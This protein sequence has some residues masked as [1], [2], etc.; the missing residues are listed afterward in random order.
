[1]GRIQLPK[2]PEK[3]IAFFIFLFFFNSTIGQMRQ[4]YVDTF[5]KDNDIRRI[6]F[7]SPST[8]YVSFKEWIGYTTDS[9]HTFTK[10]YI[11]RNNVDPNGYLLNPLASF[12]IGGV[13]AIN[14]N[15]IIAYGGYLL[16]PAILRSTDGGNTFKVVYYSQFNNMQLRT[17]VLDMIFPENNGVGYA[18]DADRILKT[19]DFGVTWNVARVDPASYFDRLEAADNKIVTAMSTGYET[20]KLLQTTDGGLVWKAVKVPELPNGKFSAAYFLSIRK[21]YVNMYDE[22]HNSYIFKTTDGGLNWSLQNNVVAASFGTTKMKFINDSIGYAMGYPGLYKTI[23]SGAVWEKLAGDN[24]DYVLNDMQIYSDNHIWA[25]GT[26]GYLEM[27][28]NGGGMPFP[29]ATFLVDTSGV[30]ATG[31]VALHNYSRADYTYRWYKNNV[32]FSTDYSPTYVHKKDEYADTI[33]LIV[34]NGATSDTLIKYQYYPKPIPPVPSIISFSPKYGQK[35]TI[36]TIAGTNFI[37]V[38]AVTFGGTPAIS[39]N[40]LSPSSITAV[41]DSGMSGEI[42]VVTAYGNAAIQGFSSLTP[43]ISSFSPKSGGPG[44]VVSIT[45]ENLNL[46][47]SPSVKF[48][49]IPATSLLILSEKEVNATVGKGASGDITYQTEY[50]V[51]TISGFTYIPPLPAPTISSFSPQK[52][53]EG[54]EV[55]II[56]ANF[57][58]ATSVTFGGIPA[59]SFIV[60]SSA[61]IKAVVGKGASGKILVTTPTGKDSLGGFEYLTP[62]IYS[63]TPAIGG[64]GTSVNIT[65][66]NFSGATSVK[67]GGV[68][69]AFYT[70]NSDTG[71]TA[72][73][74]SGASGNVSV[75]SPHGA[76]DFPGF[77]FSD[78]PTITSFSPLFGPPGTEVKIH[79]A[80][81]SAVP[82]DNIVWFGAVKAKVTSSTPNTITV[83]APPAA[84]YQPLTVSSNGLTSVSSLAFLVTFPEKEINSET[85]SQANFATGTKPFDVLVSDLDG[86]G[87]PDVVVRSIDT[88]SYFKNNSSKGALKLGSRVDLDVPGVTVNL[89]I[90]D[91]DGDGKPDIIFSK[92]NRVA[93]L[94]NTSTQGNISFAS[95]KDLGISYEVR[96]MAVGDVNG[97]GKPDIAMINYNYTAVSL[98]TSSGSTLSFTAPLQ[99]KSTYAHMP[100]SI[101]IVDFDGDGKPDIAVSNT[102]STGYNEQRN[103]ALSLYRNTFKHDTVSFEPELNYGIPGTYNNIKSADLD[104]DGKPEIVY[105]VSGFYYKQNN[106]FT[107]ANRVT[108]LTNTS[109]PGHISFVA[110][111]FNSDN[112]NGN[113]AMGVDI[114][115]INGDS[116]P[117][118]AVANF[119][120][121]VSV[122]KNNGSKGNVSFQQPVIYNSNKPN[123]GSLVSR[124]T[125]ADLD[126]DLKPELL[127]GNTL[128]NTLT[129]YRSIDTTIK[130]EVCANGNANLISDVQGS[131]YQWQVNTGAG[132]TNLN[133]NTNYSGSNTSSLQITN[134]PKTWDNYEY[135]CLVKEKFSSIFSLVV[136]SFSAPGV[137][138]HTNDTIICSGNSA[139]FHATAV[140]DGDTPS[141]QWLVDE[142]DA[143]VNSTT[144]TTSKLNNHSQIKLILTSSALCADPVKVASNIVTI[145]IKERESSSVSITSSATKICSGTGVTFSTVSIN[146]GDAPSYQWQV[147]G[148]NAGIANSSF[149]SIALKN[150]DEVKVVMSSNAS[151]LTNVTA[152]SNTIVMQV[153]DPI[154][155]QLVFDN[156]SI[157]VSNPE[158]NAN[159]TWQI[160]NDSLWLD[161]V[162]T[163]TGIIYNPPQRGDYRVK[164]ATDLCTSFSLSLSVRQILRQSNELVAILYPNPAQTMITI[165]S[166]KSE[167]DWKTLTITNAVGVSLIPVIGLQNKH[168]LTIDISVLSRGTYFVTLRKQNGKQ[169]TLTFVKN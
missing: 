96:D 70:I 95:I 86:D 164:S 91:M 140:N 31:N 165:D 7:I 124:I 66:I 63:I 2:S 84:T 90:S 18:V 161:V 78:V 163:A 93:M 75:S 25:G 44:T 68:N 122:L 1:M 168:N 47:R 98:N 45:G 41:L 128:Y 110:H 153:E 129:I 36:I 118:I 22:D 58:E 94:K 119:T 146:G 158:P 159:Y 43:I 135:R 133:D 59:A 21:G 120:D 23:N 160:L 69:A 100:N 20:N 40:V 112:L 139:T 19:V 123:K 167:D 77:Q 117:D 55:I 28:S 9:G 34:S 126:D 74:G 130:E 62:V 56:G 11:T 48:G 145:S 83:T 154:T 57:N 67:F 97:D 64:K 103:T 85:Y 61:S 39:F 142:K 72:I 134:I 141:Y 106:T 162:P 152:S 107:G 54:D 38:S 144:F 113:F 49:G 101:T 8:G 29:L 27:S 109:A 92:G 151:C 42:K 76:F 33:K 116:R 46:G 50:G 104:G 6:S 87:K 131:V 121:H 10:K 53:D 127:I 15:T 108:V 89:K 65:G 105:G 30:Y 150:K 155:P 26:H 138:I 111:D 16:V 32:P 102:F 4:V 73:I 79:G 143:G 52:A 17:A 60:T 115:N 24:N 136:N 132:F 169:T 99:L 5:N 137:T 166:L 82:S 81:F 51:A 13:K 37:G 71:I 157:A 114:G 125:I 3:I 12:A 35:G 149:E 80:N 88:I 148:V 147:N 14:K 156:H